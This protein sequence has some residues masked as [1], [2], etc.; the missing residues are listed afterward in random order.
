MLSIP[1]LIFEKSVSIGSIQHIIPIITAIG[2]TVWLIIY[3]QRHLAKKQQQQIIHVIACFVSITIICFHLYRIGFDNYDFRT[4][5]PL[6]LCSLMALIIPV[7]THYRKYWMFEILV[8]WIIGGT[9][10]GVVTPDIAVGFPSYDYF[11]YWVVHLGLLLVIFYFIIVF[12]MRPTIKSVFKSFLVLQMYV[13]LMIILNYF[14][15]ANYFYLNEKPKS[16][17]IL[18]YFGEWP[19]YILVGQLIVIPLFLLIYLPFYIFNK[20]K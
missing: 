17:S 20:G 1:L 15:D 6:Y 10:Q 9:V 4:D 5:L 8:F 16:A 12:K 3:S 13:V 11:R 7:F 14:L 2:F 19:Y 18:D